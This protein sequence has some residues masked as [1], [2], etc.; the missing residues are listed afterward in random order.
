MNTPL[1]IAAYALN[2]KLYVARPGRV[3][4]IEDL[5]VKKGF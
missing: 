4:P 5:E 1:H 3:L 2:P